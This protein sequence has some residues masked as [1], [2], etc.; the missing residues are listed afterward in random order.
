MKD[1]T[2]FIQL[3]VTMKLGAL[4]AAAATPTTTVSAESRGKEKKTQ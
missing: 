2:Y 1:R 4:A 3:H